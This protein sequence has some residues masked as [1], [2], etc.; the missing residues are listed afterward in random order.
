MTMEASHGRTTGTPPAGL[1]CSSDTP[2]HAGGS[3]SGTQ[4]M[5]E[6]LKKLLGRPIREMTGQQ[7]VLLAGAAGL[8]EEV[9]F[10]GV[11]QTLTSLWASTFFFRAFDPIF[12]ALTT[13]LILGPIV[14]A[15]AIVVTSLVFGLFHPLTKAYVVLA[16]LIS[17]YLGWLF[18]V[19]HNLLVPIL[20]HWIYDAYALY[21]FRNQLLEEAAEKSDEPCASRSSR[22]PEGP[23][24][25]DNMG[26][27]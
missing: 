21:C 7:L 13:S 27:L 1:P 6:C 2:T 5:Y 25:R 26:A 19:T 15:F 12:G 4:G 20:V 18:V 3:P 17:L 23:P 11:L 10:R 16:F 22:E 8:G 14:T 9:F 24:N